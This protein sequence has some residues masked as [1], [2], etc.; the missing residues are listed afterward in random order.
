MADAP[1]TDPRDV[2]ATLEQK[3]RRLETELRTGAAEEHAAPAAPE[4][5]AR[6]AAPQQA[7]AAHTR[8]APTGPPAAPNPAAAPPPA[9]AGP[10]RQAAAPASPEVVVE[11][12][13]F[14]DL[15]ALDAF[16][17]AVAAAPGARDVYL[18]SFD[19]G[20]AVL[21]VRLGG[22]DGA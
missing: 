3:L 10:P 20:R 12:A 6:A 11:A 5:R 19:A 13:P 8:P 4:P 21:E 1:P 7:T 2:L 17:Q 9:P 15:A 22:P 16:R 14:A 18:R